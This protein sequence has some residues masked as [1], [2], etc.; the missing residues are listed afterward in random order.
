MLDIFESILDD[1]DIAD[2]LINVISKKRWWVLL[3]IVVLLV[4]LLPSIL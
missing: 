3:I 2:L 1:Y 4:L